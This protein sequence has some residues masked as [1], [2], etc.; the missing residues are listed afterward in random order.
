MEDSVDEWFRRIESPTGS[1]VDDAH[2]EIVVDAE[3][4]SPVDTLDQ[5]PVKTKLA[6]IF[7][8]IFL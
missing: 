1:L 4:R 6:H 8:V 5:T 2:P 7:L 3:L